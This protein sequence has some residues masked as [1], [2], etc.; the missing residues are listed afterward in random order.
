MQGFV[1]GRNEARLDDV[2]SV[3]RGKR[4]V[5][6]S[7]SAYQCMCRSRR[8]I[9]Q[10]LEEQAVVYGV[11]TGFGNFS[12]TRIS[13]EQTRELQR[14]LLRSHAVAVGDPLPE[15]VVRGA[16]FLRALA[17]SRGH[18]GVRPAV[19]ELL[20]GLLNRAVTPVIPRQGSLG[21]S[22]DL[23]PLAHMALVLMGEGEAVVD[24]QVVPGA[25][26]LEKVGLRPLTLEAREGLALING[27]QIMT[28]LGALAAADARALCASADVIAGLTLEALRGISDAFDRRVS[29]V[30]T[31]PG[32]A[33]VAERIREVTAGSTL[34]TRQGELRVQDPY[35]LRCIPQVH[36]AVRDA[37]AYVIA[38]LERE[39]SAVTDNP[40]VF[41]GE[42]VLSGGNFHGEPVALVL[43][44]L[45]LAL[46]EMGNMSERRTNRLLHPAYNGGL[47]AFLTERGGLNSGLMIAHYTAASLAS[48]NKLLATPASADSIPTSAGQ[49][50]HVSM[51]TT[52]ARKA[53]KSVRNL[54]RILAIEAATAAQALDLRLMEDEAFRPGEGSGAAHAW[55]RSVVDRVEMDRSLSREVQALG[56]ALIRGDLLQ[57][58]TGG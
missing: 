10:L 7:R 9:E 55:I 3:A 27:T 22:G 32:Q 25:A 37:L 58:M 12:D 31:H 48:E 39:L 40:L 14:N 49:E 42:D 19:V 53:R 5:H 1:L 13:A 17:L 54:S 46:A 26:A 20:V 23:A 41:P 47:P 43:D 30:R 8:Y 36:G 51:G 57:R 34:V 44:H 24:G 4:E 29:R 33:E 50:D 6:L 18:S 56:D 28:A 21:T 2:V 38:T 35:S 15:D 11:T 52:A 45:A 16:M